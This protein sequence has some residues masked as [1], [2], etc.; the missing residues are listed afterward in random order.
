MATVMGRRAGEG[1]LAADGYEKALS[2]AAMLLLAAVVTALLRGHAHWA[3]V[4]GIVWAHIVTILVALALTPVILLGPR[5]DTRHRMLGRVWAGA[6]LLTAALSFGIHLTNPG[7]FSVIHILS[8]WVLIQVPVLWYAARRHRVALHRRSVRGL[9][10]GALLIAGFFTFP[11]D[12]L[13]GR[14]LFG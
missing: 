11:F 8:V 2:V 10:T 14:W 9:V 4:P 5:G 12:R 3:A 7:G 6:M 1:P 13:L